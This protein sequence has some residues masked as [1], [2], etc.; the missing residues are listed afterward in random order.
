MY[1]FGFI[2]SG[3]FSECSYILFVFHEVVDKD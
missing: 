3:V 2:L 1:Y